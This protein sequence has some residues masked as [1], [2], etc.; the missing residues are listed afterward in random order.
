MLAIDLEEHDQRAAEH[1]PR[2][3]Q[4]PRPVVPPRRSE[5]RRRDRFDD[6]IAERNRLAA[7]AASPAEREVAH[8][9]HVLEPR[10]LAPALRAGRSRPD[11]RTRRAATGRCR[12]SESCRRWR[13][14]RRR[15]RARTAAAAHRSWRTVGAAACGSS[16]SGHSG[17]RRRQLDAAVG[18]LVRRSGR[19]ERERRAARE[20]GPA[21]ASR[22]VCAACAAEVG[23]RALQRVD[24]RRARAAGAAGAR[25]P[26]AASRLPPTRESPSTSAATIGDRR[27]ARASS[28]PATAAT[29]ARR[30]RRWPCRT[31]RPPR[32]SP[33]GTSSA[34]SRCPACT[35]T[36][37]AARATPS[38]AARSPGRAGRGRGD[39]ARPERPRRTDRRC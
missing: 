11:D 8:D 2:R 23:D 38:R 16:G 35:P 25:R 19:I 37:R 29:R 14:T 15:R 18:Q 34:R 21:P 13:R 27:P 12:R 3:E 26:A 31:T 17:E 6:R 24:A 32:G 39:T 9:R 33:G 20:R 7:G 5:H 28:R 36:C 4:H 1:E 30:A 22:G 10:Q